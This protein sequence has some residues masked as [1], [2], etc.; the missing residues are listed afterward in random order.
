MVVMTPSDENECRQLLFTAT[1]LDQ[2]AAV[3][4]PR[5]PGS[6]ATLQREMNALP[7]GRANLRREG[8]GALTLLNFGPLLPAVLAAAEDQ[9]A[10]VIDMRFVKPLDRAAV[11][12]PLAARGGD[13]EENVVAGARAR[14]WPGCSPTGSVPLRT[15]HRTFIEHGSRD[16]CLAM[17]G[18][19]AAG[20]RR[21]INQWWLGLQP[22][23]PVA[24][25]G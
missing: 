4:F 7:L 15:R 24:A 14:P 5:G 22:A 6:G 11:L 21:R 19:D 2:P 16:E 18:L 9:D 20:I 8:H 25:R 13:I 3:R 12:R 10:T 1:T 23:Q 17:A